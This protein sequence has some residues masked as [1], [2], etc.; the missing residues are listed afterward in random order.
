MKNTNTITIQ[1]KATLN[2][3]GKRRSKNCEPVICVDELLPFNSVLDAA[4]HYDASPSN[5]SMCCNGK[6]Q[7]C[8]GHVFCFVKD[9]YK[10]LDLIMELSRKAKEYDIIIAKETERKALAEKVDEQRKE[11]MSFEFKM[12]ELQRQFEEAKANLASAETDL[13]NFI[14]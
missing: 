14:I 5:I 13:Q 4:E 6:Q 1:E 9:L 8:K 12:H 2:V 3:I 7:T 11:V 10:H